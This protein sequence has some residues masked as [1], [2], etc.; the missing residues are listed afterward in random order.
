MFHS[1][2]TKNTPYHPRTHEYDIQNIIGLA[3]SYHEAAD[4]LPRH[5][6]SFIGNM[7]QLHMRKTR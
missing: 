5:E 3:S 1:L 7:R 4:G 2:A 6:Y